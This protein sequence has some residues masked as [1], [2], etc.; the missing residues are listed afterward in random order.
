MKYKIN[1]FEANLNTEDI[2]VGDY[3]KILPNLDHYI[4]K[5][6]WSSIM[7]NL[8]GEVFKVEKITGRYI[9]ITNWHIPIECVSL[10]DDTKIIKRVD[11]DPYEEEYWGI[12]E[13]V[14]D[15]IKGDINIKSYSNT[16]E[17]IL[18]TRYRN[19]TNGDIK[20]IKQ[21]FNEDVMVIIDN[22]IHILSGGDNC[23]INIIHHKKMDLIE[24]ISF[25]HQRNAIES[26]LKKEKDH[27][28]NFDLRRQ[29]KFFLNKAVRFPMSSRISIIEIDDFSKAIYDL[30][31][32]PNCVLFGT[33]LD[34]KQIIYRMNNLDMMMF[35]TDIPSLVFRSVNTSYTYIDLSK[36]LR[37]EQ[38]IHKIVNRDI[39]PY[40]E[41]DWDE[42]FYEN[43][44]LNESLNEKY[45]RT[46]IA[47]D[48]FDEALNFY[49][50]MKKKGF[51]FTPD[52]GKK[53]LEEILKMSPWN[54]FIY[55]FSSYGGGYFVLS[56]KEYYIS[57]G[58]KELSVNDVLQM[59]GGNA[60]TNSR[61]RWYSKGN[62]SDWEDNNNG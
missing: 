33:D 50:K 23:D 3:V 43:V 62:F 39:D 32:I 17:N 16:W 31:K 12:E 22:K 38:I 21:L 53:R 11:I 28:K 57:K 20:D 10:V 49:E 52:Y 7:I 5:N 8:I 59:E 54:S 47:F 6:R 51:K 60:N 1:L 25:K 56:R 37:Y 29:L 13:S 45:D 19:L 26:K 44:N 2:K 24:I 36:P 9:V 35:R 58:Y 27:I 15:N 18:K 30:K 4:L 40:G 55:D 42:A 34:G 41:E 48:S 61:I 46:V 14:S